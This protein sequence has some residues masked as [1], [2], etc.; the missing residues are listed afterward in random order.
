MCND[1]CPKI[2]AQSINLTV[3]YGLEHDDIAVPCL[4]GCDEAHKNRS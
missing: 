3:E 4:Q 2:S 1:E